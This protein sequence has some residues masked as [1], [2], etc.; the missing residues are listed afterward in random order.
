MHAS[1]D[2]ALRKNLQP[3][4]LQVFL[5]LAFAVVRNSIH[6]YIVYD[7]EA[8]MRTTVTIDDDL[9]NQALA[10]ADPAMDKGD[11]FREAVKAF[12][13]M[14]LARR[15]AALGGTAPSMAD[16]PRRHRHPVE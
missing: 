12:V 7:E 8:L 16:V 9:Y 14:R 11:L 4:G 3:H 5:R 6:T 2:A 10:V 13:E 1:G 15:L